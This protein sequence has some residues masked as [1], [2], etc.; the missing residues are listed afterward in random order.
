MSNGLVKG[1]KQLVQSL[2]QLC[3]QHLSDAFKK[4][5]EVCSSSLVGLAARAESNRLQTLYLD[6]Q[7]LL[8][9]Q[10]S[11][12]ESGDNSRGLRSFYI[13]W[14]TRCLASQSD[15]AFAADKSPQADSLSPESDSLKL[16]GHE[17]LEGD[18]CAG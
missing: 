7:R 13:R 9:K 16:L 6:S 11:A 3:Q 14:T 10:R 4:F 2:G 8:R 15:Q 5:N 12:I 17:D 1:N 18:D